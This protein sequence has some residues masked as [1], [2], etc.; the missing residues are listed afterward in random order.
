MNSL[1]SLMETPLEIANHDPLGAL[2]KLPIGDWSGLM[3]F[4][5]IIVLG[6]LLVPSLFAL[7]KYLVTLIESKTET[8]V[9]PNQESARFL[10]DETIKFRIEL[11]NQM[12]AI[13]QLIKD[14]KDE[15]I[16]SKSPGLLEFEIDVIRI[17]HKHFDSMNKELLRFFYQRLVENHID[18]N[19]DDISTNYHQFAQ[20]LSGRFH[21]YLKHWN[22][23]GVPL[24]NFTSGDGAGRYCRYIV[25]EL[26]ALQVNA[27]EESK[28]VN[29][30]QVSNGLA[31]CTSTLLSQ[32]REYL[33]TGDTFM[34]QWDD[35]KPM[36]K[37]ISKLNDVE[38]L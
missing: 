21:G 23:N 15:V 22:Y 28:Q 37:I 12:M 19:Q 26:F 10:D 24:S 25:S 1:D 11:A 14:L 3:W 38:M 35:T 7:K 6:I 18:T 31:R 20:D 5:V 13:T 30:I 17:V 29:L 2:L 8:I 4:I 9:T 34:E 27:Y 32:F 16:L 33:S 36:Y